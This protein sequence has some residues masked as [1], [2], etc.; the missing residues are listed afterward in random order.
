[1]TGQALVIVDVQVGLF[2]LANL[3]QPDNPIRVCPASEVEF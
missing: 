2:A 3:V 1:M